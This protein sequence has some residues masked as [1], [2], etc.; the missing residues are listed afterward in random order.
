MRVLVTGG[1]GFI[2]SHLVDAF[3]ER[4]A[5]VSVVDNLTTGTRANVRPEATVH[6]IDIRDRDAV[7]RAF[8][9][10]TPDVVLHLAAQADVRRSMD[11]PGYDLDVN[12]RGTIHLLEAGSRFGLTRMVF[13]STGGAIY[14]EPAEIPVAEGC[15][16]APT[17]CYG[18]SKAAA[19]VYLGVYAESA[20]VRASV[21]RFANVYGP[22]QNP[23]G[24]A[25]VVAIF[26][27]KMLE[28][29][30]CT[31]FGDGSK[32]RDY[33]YIDDIVDAVGRAVDGDVDGT[34]NLGTGQ[35]TSDQ[36][37]FDAVRAAVGV[38]A[39]PHYGARRRGEVEHIALDATRA[40]ERLGWQPKVEF[41]DGVRRAVAYYRGQHQA[42]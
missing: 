37:V 38:D 11:D 31:I 1:A 18:A 2:G 35:P 42:G 28:G 30:R 27:L 41:E 16:P 39:E 33:V 22:R 5:R 6:E 34:F 26:S 20:G 21:L 19:E 32:T 15:P 36:Q 23:K 24:E 12:V 8:E 25:G 7:F 29:E 40:A 17:S 13:A 3:H 4:G 10:E 9:A 14:G